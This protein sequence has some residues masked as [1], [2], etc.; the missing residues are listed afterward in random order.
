MVII[1]RVTIRNFRNLANVDLRLPPGTVLV[2]ENWSGKS[3]L[4][5]AIRLVL[6]PIL[7]GVDRQLSR[8]DFRD[9]LSGGTDGWDPIAA[10]ET[11]EISIEIVDFVNE[12]AIA[13]ALSDALVAADPPRAPL[14]CRFAP[15]EG[16][17]APSG[18]PRYPVASS[19]ATTRIFPAKG[20]ANG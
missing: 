20:A 1:D 7:S 2:G 10:G 6:D 13:T 3:N 9:G 19:A 16:Q 8:D 17:E 4:I 15:V 11:A 14:T 18:K 5:Y 12:P